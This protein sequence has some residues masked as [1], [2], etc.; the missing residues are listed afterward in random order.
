MF[1]DLLQ[2]KKIW[3][4][5]WPMILGG[6]STPLLG[7][8]DTALLGHIESSHYLSA[9]AVGASVIGLL[10][11]G[12]GF[13]RMGTTSLVARQKG[14]SS[15]ETSAKDNHEDILY[16]GLLIALLSSSLPLLAS[17]W[18]IDSIVAWMNASQAIDQLSVE[19][20]QLRLYSTPA[21]FITFVITGWLIGAQ[22]TQAAL[23]IALCANL[24][25]IALDLLFIGQ[26]GMNSAGAA[27]ASV[28]AEYS[29]A[30]LGLYLISPSL[31]FRRFYRWQQWLVN[32]EFRAL[33]QLNYHLFFRTLLVLFSLSF[34]TAQGAAMGDNIVA[35]NAI[36]LQLVMLSAYVMDG[37][38]F[39]AEALCGEASGKKDRQ[40]FHWHTLGCGLFVV[41][42]GLLF[43]CL[44]FMLG[45]EIIYL[46]SN[47][48]SIN[49]VAKAMLPW[50][51]LM[52]MVGAVAYLFDGVY[53][54]C[55][56]VK[57]MHISLWLGILLIYLPLWWLFQPWQNH[58]L[59][60]AL[61]GFTAFRGLSLAFYYPRLLAN[62]HR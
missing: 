31:S 47:I 58:G 23:A 18:L 52:P 17:P 33:L 28:L 61:L 20:I 8:V 7:L 19:Y 11:W 26:L 4:I 27:I 59:W 34:F 12:F 44:Y 49:N 38:S 21:V 5:A 43:S 2:R 29:A 14:R 57:A 15:F 16:R 40:A 32:H 6:L 55:G 54:G 9:V 46:L 42:T 22:R 37:F 41:V 25:N 60:L 48:E 62:I 30:I 10:Y 53:I 51:A 39:A 1:F 56:A 3:A 36:L 13:L 35:A 45:P 24:L 50:L